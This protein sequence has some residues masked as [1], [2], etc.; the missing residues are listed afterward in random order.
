MEFITEA[1]DHS[2]EGKYSPSVT[3]RDFNQD[4][5]DGTELKTAY[6]N[7]H[8]VGMLTFDEL[9]A[10]V[11]TARQ[12][13]DGKILRF[14]SID[15]LHPTKVELV[16]A[17]TTGTSVGRM[18]EVLSICLATNETFIDR[19]PL[20]SSHSLLPTSCSTFPHCEMTSSPLNIQP[21]LTGD[22]FAITQ[23]ICK[24]YKPLAD[25]LI[26]RGLSIEWL[27]TD[28][29]CVGHTGPDCDATDRIVWPLLLICEPGVDDIPY[30]RPIEGIEMRISLL[31]EEVIS[32]VDKVFHTKYI[33]LSC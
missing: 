18:S 32:F 9:V 13:H 5:I 31:R 3:D 23:K 21:A 6:D 24:A 7:H 25:A 8:F 20:I 2:S 26:A 14:I 27:N 19:I 15:Y 16:M 29:W 22:E 10:S 17:S 12:R 1:A 28:A 33:V 4:N 11:N 30:A